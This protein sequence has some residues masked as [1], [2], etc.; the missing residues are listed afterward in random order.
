MSRG[1]L[2]TA[3]APNA[4]QILHEGPD[5]GFMRHSPTID[6]ES[7]II[8]GRR[9]QRILIAKDCPDTANPSTSIS[10]SVAVGSEQRILLV[11]CVRN[12]EGDDGGRLYG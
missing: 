8:G 2:E 4:G 3:G 11:I 1:V 10:Q 7:V 12:C 5:Q 6:G 9:A